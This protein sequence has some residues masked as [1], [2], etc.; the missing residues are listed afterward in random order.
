MGKRTPVLV[1]AKPKYSKEPFEKLIKRFI[2]KV[3]REK[4]IENWVEKK[5]YV[6][7]SEARRKK[8]KRRQKVLQKLHKENKFPKT[9]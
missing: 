6:K 4:I 1:E 3:K 5:A 2:K 7:P 8:E 9:K